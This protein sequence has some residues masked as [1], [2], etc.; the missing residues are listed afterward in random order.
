MDKVP[1]LKMG[2]TLILA[3]QVELHD[4]MAIRLQEDI[5]KEIHDTGA[6]GLVIDVSA[7]EVVDSFM[8]RVLS[9]TASMAGI[10][11]VETALVGIRPEIAITL[12]EMGLELKGVH[13]ALNLEKGMELLQNIGEIF[14]GE[15]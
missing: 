12:Q 7:L 11:G 9:D 13:F 14:Y 10:M 3:I 6:R 15:D 1:I 2:D 4:K 5:L 8:G